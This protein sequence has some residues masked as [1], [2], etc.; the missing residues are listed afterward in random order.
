MKHKT[1]MIGAMIASTLSLLA[2]QP[3]Q[4]DTDIQALPTH[5]VFINA[6]GVFKVKRVHTMC[7]P[8]Q[9]LGYPERKSYVS[10]IDTAKCEG[11][12]L[13]YG[14]KKVV[15]DVGTG[16]MWDFA[17]EQLEDEEKTSLDNLNQIPIKEEDHDILMARDTI[18]MPT[19]DDVPPTPVLPTKEQIFTHI[20]DGNYEEAQEMLNTLKNATSPPL[21]RGDNINGQQISD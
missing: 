12:G 1:L 2:F 10:V 5:K 19:P 8:G 13:P 3:T 17:L 14:L 20:Q 15:T 18:M 7:F 21:S 4:A 9:I 6:H 16:W 11:N